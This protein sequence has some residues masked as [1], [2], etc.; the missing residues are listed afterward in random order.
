MPKFD[1][2]FSGRARYP[3]PNGTPIKDEFI[4]RYAKDGS[5]ELVPNGQTNMYQFIQSHADSV[6]IHVLLQRYRN[7]D[8]LALNRVQ[9]FYA[10]VADMPKS[11]ADVLNVVQDGE[12]HFMSLPKDVRAQFDHS[13]AKWLAAM[14]SPAWM[15]AMGFDA[16]KVADVAPVAPPVE[17][18]PV[19]VVETEVSE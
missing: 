17:P 6:D 3:Q 7:G 1:T 12:R 11:F 8:D 18:V 14:G 16:Q 13:F 5:I 2:Q 19:P 9:G 15:S 10:D 4:G